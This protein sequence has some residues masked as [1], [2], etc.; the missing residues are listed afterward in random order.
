[1]SGGRRRQA[2]YRMI[3]APGDAQHTL[4]P[5]R[6]LCSGEGYTMVRRPGATTRPFIITDEDWAHAPLR[7][8][9]A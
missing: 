4:L 1:M 9:E 5:A 2:E 3:A 6:V 7:G 8:Q